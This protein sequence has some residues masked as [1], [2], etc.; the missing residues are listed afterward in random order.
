MYLL[1]VYFLELG[2]SS[3]VICC[4]HLQNYNTIFN[5]L[6]LTCSIVENLSLQCLNS[7]LLFC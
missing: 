1:E 4:C 3:R 7:V 6:G 2:L 5:R